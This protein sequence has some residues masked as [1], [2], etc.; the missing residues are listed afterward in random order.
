MF[1]SIS[2]QSFDNFPNHYKLGNF[3]VDTDNGWE[4]HDNG[5]FFVLYKG[6]ADCDALKNLI[7]QIIADS[8]PVLQ[9]N[10]CLL[11]FDKYNQTL[12]IHT[13]RY[14]SFPIYYQPNHI[15]N[16]KKLQSTAWS[17]SIVFI[18]DQF[19]VIEEKFD[20]I[21]SIECSTL[22]RQEVIERINSILETKTK[23]FL[24]HNKLPVKAFLSGGV[25][26]CLV[27]SYLQKF[28]N[29][30]QLIDYQHIDYDYFWTK[31]SGD[32]RSLWGYTQIH[33]WRD[34]CILTSGTP[35]DEY[36][37][38]NPQQV[39]IF[40]KY[41]GMV[42][43]DLLDTEQYRQSLHYSYYNRPKNLKSFAEQ[44]VDTEISKTEFF[45]QLCNTVVNDWQHWHL[46]NTLTWTPLRDLEIFKLILRLPIND[47]IDQ[48]L[49]SSVSVSL[50]EHNS[51]G[52]SSVISD[53]KNTGNMLSN[54]T[55]FLAK[56]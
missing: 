10:F 50:I 16:L 35:G 19:A 3:F 28:S 20:L 17:D 18:D 21:G 41:H 2:N 55:K 22:S 1:F 30:Y 4:S 26:T 40:L 11:A 51:P 42:L 38:R 7:D 8:E 25:D 39:D 54:L 23:S 48:A 15:T 12:K 29:N 45:W 52:L 6:Y 46:G 49:D 43:T 33:H 34:L 14:R 5:Q 47:A 37:L 13:D 53:Q 9:G 36:T 32:L 56:H 31:N 27:Y 24:S 44:T